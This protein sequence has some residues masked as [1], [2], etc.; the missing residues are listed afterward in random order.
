MEPFPQEYEIMELFETEPTKLDE[1]V[2]FFYNNNTYKL[3]RPNGNL[4][5]E[6]EPGS[7]WTR[8]AWKQEGDLVIDL[9]LEKVKGIEIEKRSGKE[10]LKVYF[11]E[12][13]GLRTLVIKTKPEISIIWGTLRG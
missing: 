6:I 3:C 1:E 10:F 13:Q 11:D 8:I 4:Y 5:F 9:I 2:S 12:E 7:H